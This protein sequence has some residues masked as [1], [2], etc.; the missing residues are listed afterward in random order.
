MIALIMKINLR[1]LYLYLFSFV[2]LLVTVIGSVQMVNLGL[3]TFFLKDADRYPIYPMYA[4]K[5]DPGYMTIEEQMAQ[6]DQQIKQQRQ[7]ELASSLSM[8]IIGAPLYFYHWKMV[9]KKN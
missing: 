7:N 5:D 9:Q 2:G 6:Q 4:D 8:I 3:K 1:L